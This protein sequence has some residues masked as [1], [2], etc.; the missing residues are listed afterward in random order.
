MSFITLFSAPKPFTNPH[1]ATIQRNAIRSWLNLGEQVQVVLIGSEAGLAE[2]AAELGVCHLPDVKRNELGTPL[3]SS[4]FSL[5][6]EVSD[7]PVL[8]Y[9]NGDILLLPDFVAAVRQVT[10]QLER[11]LLISQRWD[12]AVLQELDFSGNWQ[13]LL[14]AELTRQGRLHPPAGSDLFVFPRSE[15]QNLPEFAIGRAGWD[16]WMIYAARKNDIPVVDA[17]PSITVIHQDHDYSHLP[18]GKPHYDLQE[19]Q[20]NMQLGGGHGTMYMILD[21]THRLVNGRVKPPAWSLLRFVRRLELW[22]MPENSQ[23]RGWRWGIARKLRRW[24]RRQTHSRI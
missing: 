21:C 16:N 4:I 1:I 13:Q 5:A 7:S 22:L 24:R 20:I 19:S 12:L 3:V 11:F 14:K 18:E 6:R 2:T 23:R 10:S 8:A 9:V 15:F 17:T